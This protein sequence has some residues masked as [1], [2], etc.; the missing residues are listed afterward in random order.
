M[1]VEEPQRE[2][3]RPEH[4]G[5]YVTWDDADLHIVGCGAT[6]QEALDQ[7]LDAGVKEPTV[8]YVPRMDR[9]F[10]GGL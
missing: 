8:E 5:K 9:L 6:I 7:A 2:M 10:V 4:S 1:T 3:P